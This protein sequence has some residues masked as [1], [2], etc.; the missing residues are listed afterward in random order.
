M[1]FPHPYPCGEMMG[2]LIDGEGKDH[3]HY[4]YIYGWR[5]IYYI[6]I[7]IHMHKYWGLELSGWRNYYFSMK[8]FGLQKLSAEVMELLLFQH[9][10]C[11]W[12]W[13]LPMGLNIHIYSSHTTGLVTNLQWIG[14]ILN[15]GYKYIQSMG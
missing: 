10:L 4:N 6:I 7:F 2:K 11:V 5:D 12:R 13:R 8:E 1:N 14:M 3:K 9:E 15:G